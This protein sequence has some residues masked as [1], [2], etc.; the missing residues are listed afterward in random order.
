MLITKNFIKPQINIFFFLLKSTEM[1][2]IQERGQDVGIRNLAYKRQRGAMETHKR[3]SRE[4]ILAC[5]YIIN[6]Y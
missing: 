2:S 3:T 1:S 6:I 5:E 4:F